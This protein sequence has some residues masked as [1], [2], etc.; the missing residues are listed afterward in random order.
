LLRAMQKRTGYETALAP[1]AE[2]FFLDHSG[3]LSGAD[4]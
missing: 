1:Q 2:K 4:V 3:P